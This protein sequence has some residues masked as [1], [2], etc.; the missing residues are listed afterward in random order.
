MGRQINIL[1]KSKATYTKEY[2]LSIRQKVRTSQSTKRKEYYTLNPELKESTIYR[3]PNIPEY[4]RISFT[5]IRLSS[6]HLKIETGRWSRIP[7]EN[8]LCQCNEGIQSEEHVLLKCKFTENLR[9]NS[10]EINNCTNIKDL[11]K[12]NNEAEISR[13]CYQVIKTYEQL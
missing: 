2:Q 7:R 13:L 5:R 10:D 1:M 12:C 11:F 6:H 8:R 9:V 3:N 4:H